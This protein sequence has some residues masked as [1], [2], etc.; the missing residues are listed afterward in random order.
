MERNSWIASGTGVPDELRLPEAFSALVI[1]E[2][3]T[4]M[5]KLRL[6]SEMLRA[7]ASARGLFCTKSLTYTALPEKKSV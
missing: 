6:F 3:S 4:L 7:E 2:S 5:G 1:Q